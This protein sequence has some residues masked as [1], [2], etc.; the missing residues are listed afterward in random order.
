ME[1]GR[2]AD[3]FSAFPNSADSAAN[4]PTEV[5]IVLVNEY[6]GI[7]LLA[8]YSDGGAK[9]IS[10]SQGRLTASAGARLT[11][12][13]LAATHP[14]AIG[15]KFESYAAA[16]SRTEDAAV[17]FAQSGRQAGVQSGE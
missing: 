6:Y 11:F 5:P 4:W 9:P 12:A 15:G 7:E 1:A 13:R 14:V 3:P 2:L 17:F 8:W 16:S 10:V